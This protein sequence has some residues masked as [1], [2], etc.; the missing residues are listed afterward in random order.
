MAHIVKEKMMYLRNQLNEWNK[1]VYGVLDVNIKGLVKD[2]NI[3]EEEEVSEGN[4]DGEK[5][6]PLNNEFWAALHNK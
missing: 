6:K 3:M 5:W 4:L 2:L 1:D